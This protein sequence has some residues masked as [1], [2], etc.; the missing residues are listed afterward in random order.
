MGIR[1]IYFK[2]NCSKN[3]LL[4]Y[5]PNNSHKMAAAAFVQYETRESKSM[6]QGDIINNCTQNID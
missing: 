5:N 2:S 6:V 4:T 3:G 1:D